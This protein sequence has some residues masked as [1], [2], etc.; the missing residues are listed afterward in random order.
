MCRGLALARDRLDHDAKIVGAGSDG[1]EGWAS[2]LAERCLP[3]TGGAVE[4]GEDALGRPWPAEE[5]QDWFFDR[6]DVESG[7][8]NAAASCRQEGD[9]PGDR[10]ALDR[11]IERVG[12][13][14]AGLRV[15]GKERESELGEQEGRDAGGV[16]GRGWFPLEGGGSAFIGLE[17][18]GGLGGGLS[19]LGGGQVEGTEDGGLGQAA[20]LGE[21][22]QC[23]GHA[24]EDHDLLFYRW[25]VG[26]VRSAGR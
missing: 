19:E 9:G 6:W 3:I 11:G 18:P 25:S 4:M 8:A 21:G 15:L 13:V 12:D 5:T 2:G 16:V 10:V 20:V 17:D 23:A 22:Q 14:W 7:E 1:S 26:P 24:G